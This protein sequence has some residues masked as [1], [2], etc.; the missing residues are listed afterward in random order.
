MPTSVPEHKF[1]FIDNL[2]EDI[3]ICSESE[4]SSDPRACKTYMF[5]A[6]CLGIALIAA[7]DPFYSNMT[8]HVTCSFYCAAGS[9]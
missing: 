4:E 7:R 2:L 1:S 6:K 9:N 5:I 3:G 8:K